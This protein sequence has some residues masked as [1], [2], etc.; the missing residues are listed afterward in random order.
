MAKVA[1]KLAKGGDLECNIIGF[2]KLKSEG[3]NAMSQV[4]EQVVINQVI[5]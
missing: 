2:K 4:V 3:M 5:H 1:K